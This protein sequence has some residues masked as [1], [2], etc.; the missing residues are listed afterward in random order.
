MPRTVWGCYIPALHL[1]RKQTVI[2][3]LTLQDGNLTL[4]VPILDFDDFFAGLPSSIDP[5]LPV[6]ELGRSKVVAEGSPI[7][8][9]LVLHGLNMLG[10]A[11]EASH[12]EAMVYRFKVETA[13]RDLAH[14]Q[15]EMLE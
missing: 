11:L 12:K 3:S 14:M 10:S 9:G 15:G 1:A 6:D 5:P 4:L 2:L 7:I 8:N 13:E